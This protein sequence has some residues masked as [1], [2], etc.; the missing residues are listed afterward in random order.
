MTPAAF[1]DMD[2]TVVR[3]N[4]ASLYARWQVRTGQARRR[5]FARVSW[6]MLRYSLGLVDARSIARRAA[7]PMAGTDESTFAD[8]VTAWVRD[9]VL[10][11]VTNAARSEVTLRRKQGYT[12]ALLTTSTPYAAHPV[13]AA[14]GIDHVISSR[15]VVRDGRFTGEVVEPLCYG[16]GKVTLAEAWAHDRDVDLR[17]SVFFTD[18]I[19]DVPMLERVGEPVAVNPDPRLRIMAHRRGWPIR[20]WQR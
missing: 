5:D 9:E 18:S 13:A 17:A 20:Q 8:R 10:P 16:D 6:W 15:L 14:L 1:F 4:T 2:G 3:I 12:C 19:S 11:H 7:L